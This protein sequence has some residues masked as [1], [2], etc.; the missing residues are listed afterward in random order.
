MLWH[1]K[2]N[3]PPQIV[4]FFTKVLIYQ[5]D[6]LCELLTAS[7]EFLKCGC[8]LLLTTVVQS[9]QVHGGDAHCL[10]AVPVYA[11][12]TPFL[13]YESDSYCK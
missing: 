8:C 1:N 2:F 6:E 4:Q 10:W 13:P 11:M 7:S 12:E 5:V 3:P 9:E